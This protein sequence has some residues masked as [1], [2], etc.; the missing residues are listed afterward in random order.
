MIRL[1]L[2]LVAGVFL[3]LLLAGQDRG[4]LRDGLRLADAPAPKAERVVVAEPRA[5]VVDAVF[6]PQQPVAQAVAAPVAATEITPE[7]V[8]EAPA[9][10]RY[11]VARSANVRSGPSTDD[12]ILGSI[13]NG[14]AVLLVLDEIPVEGWSRVR[15]EGDGID[16]YVASRLLGDE[17]PIAD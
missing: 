11:V 8:A 4:Q 17:N 14:E 2:V 3:T 5:T 12:S 16:G 15:I 10:L 9:A 6:V 7:P 1:T 13:Q